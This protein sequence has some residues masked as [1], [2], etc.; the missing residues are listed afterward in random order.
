MK[1]FV[2]LAESDE[3]VDEFLMAKAVFYLCVQFNLCEET[4]AK[5]ILLQSAKEAVDF[6]KYMNRPEVKPEGLAK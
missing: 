1:L 5:M 3:G 2:E 4:V 6:G